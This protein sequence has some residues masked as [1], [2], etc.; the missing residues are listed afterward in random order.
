MLTWHDMSDILHEPGP[1]QCRTSNVPDPRSHA[2]HPS[3]Y[4][5][6]MAFENCFHWFD[7]GTYLAGQ[8][9]CGACYHVL[10]SSGIMAFWYVWM[11][12]AQWLAPSRTLHIS[13]SSQRC[14]SRQPKRQK[15]YSFPVCMWSGEKLARASLNPT[16]RYPGLCWSTRTDRGCYGASI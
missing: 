15:V 11:M 9:E 16:C 4:L 3:H 2:C 10:T 1:L 13:Q 7:N 5:R 14:C 8:Y 12:I 6:S